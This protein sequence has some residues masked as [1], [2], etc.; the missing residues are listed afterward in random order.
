[1]S[2]TLL[3]ATNAAKTGEKQLP[4]RGFTHGFHKFFL[5]RGVPIIG[6]LAALKVGADA[7]ALDAQAF[8]ITGG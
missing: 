4:L 6:A 2:G 3:T 1:M 7:K 8:Q 5:L